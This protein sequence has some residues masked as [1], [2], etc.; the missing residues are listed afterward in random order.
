MK[1]NPNQPRKVSLPFTI[2]MLAVHLGAIWA[3]FHTTASSIIVC[4]V[5]VFLTNCIG[6]SLGMHRLFSH[7]SFEVLPVMRYIIGI[8]STLAFQGSIGQWVGHHRMH[9]AGSDTDNDPHNAKRG[10]FYSHMGWL[11]APHKP[12]TDAKRITAFARDIYADPVLKR[13]STKRFMVGLQLT[14]ALSLF[15]I[16][17]LSWFL[18]GICM[19]LVIC[20][21]CTWL[22]NSACHMFGYQNFA[23]EDRARNN[24]IV[25]L[26]S[27]GEGWHNNHHAHP[28]SAKTGYRFWEVD[29]T[30]MVICLL[31]ALRLASAVKVARPDLKQGNPSQG[32][33]PQGSPRHAH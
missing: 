14:L 32:A 16:G 8:F 24:G 13:M 18:W 1:T 11:L 19:R 21:H 9:H 3:L 22:V 31:K 7:R 23:T 17:G 10:F 5:L 6:V 30:Y 33:A 12:F 26:L 2:I 20:Y 27:W 29:V 28:E 4:G 15:L 25:A